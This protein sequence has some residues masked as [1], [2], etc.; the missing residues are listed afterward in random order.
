MWKRKWIP[1]LLVPVPLL[2]W[3]LAGWGGITHSSRPWYRWLIDWWPYEKQ[4]LYGHGALLAL[5]AVLPVVISPLVMP[6]MIVGIWQSLRGLR[7]GKFHRADQGIADEQ[8]CHLQQSR[9]LTALLPLFVLTAHS[10]LYWLGDMGSFGEARYLLVV[11]PFWGVLSA[12][13]W[14]WA[15][16]RLQWNHPVRWAAIAVVPLPILANAIEIPWCRC[17]TAR[18]GKSAIDLADEVSK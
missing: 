10:L 13:G 6:A 1:L 15:F 12:R 9:A 2:L 5:V 18:I 14:E 16:S 7:P 4:S 3:D 11:A 8:A 17:I